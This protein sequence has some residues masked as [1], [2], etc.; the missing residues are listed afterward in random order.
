[1][2]LSDFHVHSS[3]SPDS[4]EKMENTIE[5]AISLGVKNLCFTDHH[6]I[7]MPI[8]EY[9]FLLDFDAYSNTFFKLKSKYNNL[10]NLYFGIEL[11]IQP[12]IYSILSNIVRKYPF[13]FVLCSQHVVDGIDPYRSGFFDNKSKTEAYYRYFEVLL[14]NLL[15]YSDFDVFAHLDYITRYGPYEDKSINYS[16]LQE[17]LD[18]ILITTIQKEKGIEINTSGFK[19][20][21]NPHPSFEIIKRYKELG[22]EIITV[23]SD[24]HLSKNL[25]NYFKEAEEILKAAGFKYYTIFKN[26]KP[27][28]I[29]L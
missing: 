21:N 2:I 7:D 13:D 6:D 10:I 23:G 19:Y 11:G 3:F 14:D 17:I 26:R 15:N 18:K 22:G 20:V 27:E 28:F 5:Y 29:S 9:N 12:H 4:K 24:S 1:M 16:D 8:L 25:L